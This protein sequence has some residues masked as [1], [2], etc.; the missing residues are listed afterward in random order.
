MFARA[1]ITGGISSSRPQFQRITATGGS[2]S[3]YS[4]G[5]NTYTIHTFTSSSTFTITAGADTV[6]Y[7]VVAGGGGGGGTQNNASGSGYGGEATLSSGILTVGSYAVTVGGG[8][9]GVYWSFS[10][11]AGAGGSSSFIGTGA[12]ETASGGQGGTSTYYSGGGYSSPGAP[13]YTGGPATFTFPSGTSVTYGNNGPYRGLNSGY[14]NGAANTGNGGSNT[15][16]NGNTRGGNG[17][18]GI[19]IVRYIS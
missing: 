2:I 3:T 17:G 16:S 13:G 12:S 4:D 11:T 9:G 6:E 18:S 10:A 19:V 7:L 14:S 5:T 8:G 1:L 15:W